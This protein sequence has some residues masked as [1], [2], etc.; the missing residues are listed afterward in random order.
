MKYV[1]PDI[2]NCD[3]FNKKILLLA[4]LDAPLSEENGTYI[5]DDETRL[6]A[7]LPTIRFLVEKGAHIIVVGKAGRPE[8]KEVPSLSLLPVAKWLYSN[9]GTVETFEKAQV[10][11]FKGWRIHPSVIVLE[12]VR[13]YKEEEQ[14]DPDFCKKLAAN[15]DIYVN[16]AFAM[17]HRKHASVFGVA[18][19]LPHFAGIH[20]L[21]EVRVLG[22]VL[23]NPKRPLVIIIGGKKLETKLP[24]VEKMYG[25]ADFVLVGGKIAQEKKEIVEMVHK[26][27]RENKT[28]LLVATMQDLGEDVTAQ[29]V[30]TFEPI[31]EQAATI[32]WNGSMGMIGT[33]A[34]PLTSEEGTKL[35]VEMIARSSAYKIVG[36]GDTV[37]YVEKLGKTA[38]FDFVSTGGGAM[39]SFLSGEPLAGLQAL[40]EQFRFAYTEPLSQ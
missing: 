28:Q 14:N 29:S 37:E 24:L 31:I 13:F 4:D 20:L 2:R 3:V 35:L 22:G 7:G 39:L 16:D 10:D 27:T 1:L 36:G 40:T 5:I 34:H 32:V 26:E 12:N 19:L 8:G 17:S 33:R 11:T 38:L 21:E 30:M 23:E 6:K 9:L 15:A 18:R 25:F